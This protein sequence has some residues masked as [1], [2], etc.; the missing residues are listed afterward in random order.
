MSDHLLRSEAV[1]DLSAAPRARLFTTWGTVLYI[2]VVSGEL[3]HGPANSSPANAVFVADPTSKG[4][5]RRGWLMHASGKA[6]E[7]VICL[8]EH[9]WAASSNALTDAT[10]P[11]THFQ[12]VTLERGLFGLKS[13]NSYLSAEP[14]GRITL[15]RAVCS[16][17]ENFAPSAFWCPTTVVIDESRLIANPNAT[18]NSSANPSAALGEAHDSP[19]F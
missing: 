9:S 8:A 5:L 12:F 16:T 6:L 7:P 17:W 13:G 2:D 1:P 14:N 11:P 15:S 4:E 18:I 10:L 19:H 3:R